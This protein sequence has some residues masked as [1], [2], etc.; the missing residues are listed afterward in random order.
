LNTIGRILAI[1]YVLL[2]LINVRVAHNREQVSFYIT[3]CV[4]MLVLMA[5]YVT[6]SSTLLPAIVLALFFA[7]AGDVLLLYRGNTSLVPGGLAFMI[8]HVLYSWAFWQIGHPSGHGQAYLIA[9]LFYI[10]IGTWLY[11]KFM[12]NLY[13]LTD[14]LKFGLGLYMTVILFMSFS[15]LLILKTDSIY[16]F[17]PLAGS[18]LF[19]FSDYLLALGSIIKNTVIYYPWAM[20]SYLTAQFLIVGGLILMGF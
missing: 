18:L 9:A 10:G 20:A 3:K 15:S 4:L 1:A 16:T 17:L 6:S 7:W 19:I 12:R 8:G 13:Q 11:L 2:S 5:V 14:S